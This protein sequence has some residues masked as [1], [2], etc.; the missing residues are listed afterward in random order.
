MRK[1]LTNRDMRA[2]NHAHLFEIPLDPSNGIDLD[3]ITPGLSDAAARLHQNDRFCGAIR[4]LGAIYLEDGTSLLHGDFYPGSWVWAGTEPRIIDPEFCFVGPPEYD[5]GVMLAHLVMAD[6]P[7][8][9][10]I[11][12]LGAYERPPGFNNRLADRFVGME[13][14]RRLIGVAQVPL[15]RDL[16]WKDERLSQAHQLVIG[17]ERIVA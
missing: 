16:Q 4:E 8:D 15:V 10:R 9:I 3:A 6:C 12:T 14:M 17:E 1:E 5:V 13:I 2:L 7:A 11:A